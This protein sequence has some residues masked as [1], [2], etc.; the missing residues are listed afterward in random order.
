MP[1]EE[2]R[3]LISGAV[4]AQAKHQGSRA[5]PR[6]ARRTAK[7]QAAFPGP[8]RGPISQPA[9]P[10]CA[11]C[12]RVTVQPPPQLLG[13]T[14]CSRRDRLLHR[15][16]LC[17][18]APPLRPAGRRP[19]ADWPGSTR[20]R[21]FS[22]SHTYR[23]HTAALPCATSPANNAKSALLTD[24]SPSHLPPGALQLSRHSS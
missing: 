14:W 10:N 15:P 23:T 3:R 21:R 13:T 8:L 9:A 1:L 22:A 6:L 16:V 20:R 24:P 5:S 11:Q 4:G 7:P 12:W 19:P 17:Q 2:G 18:V